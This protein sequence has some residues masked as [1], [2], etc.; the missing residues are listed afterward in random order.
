METNEKPVA[1][2]HN[3]QLE[4][5]VFASGEDYRKYSNLFF[6]NDVDNGSIYS[7]GD[8]SDPDNTARSIVYVATWLPERPIWNLEHDHVHYLD[9]RYNLHGDFEDYGFDT[10]KTL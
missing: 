1:D 7:E 8:P 10:H 5:V 2:D 4:L 6:G 9:G 3:D